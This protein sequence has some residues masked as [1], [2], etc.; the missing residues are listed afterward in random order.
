[1]ATIVHLHA[2][3]AAPGDTKC[4]VECG[5]ECGDRTTT[6]YRNLDPERVNCPECLKRWTR[7]ISEVMPAS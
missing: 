4:R 1:M 6:A 2:R 3:Y 7:G 5:R